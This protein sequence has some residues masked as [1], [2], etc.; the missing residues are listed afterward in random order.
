MININH[1]NIISMIEA[2]RKS[3]SYIVTIYTEGGCY[4]FHLLLRYFAPDA[5]PMINLRGDH[6]VSEIMGRYYD[7]RGEIT[8]PKQIY[9]KPTDD[10]LKE[11]KKWSFGG[12]AF[13][14]IGEC[15][16]C[17]EPLLA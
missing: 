13:L 2:F 17:D 6:I 12:K 4:Q 8:H 16:V 9:R 3:D 1:E 7:I 10:E 14:Q 15:P 5:V 11:A